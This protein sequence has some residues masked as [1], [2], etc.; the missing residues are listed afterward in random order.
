MDDPDVVNTD[1][2]SRT[3]DRDQ[4]AVVLPDRVGRDHTD[5]TSVLVMII[6]RSGVR[7]GN[8]KYWTVVFS[9][10]VNKYTQSQDAVVGV[11]EECPVLMPLD[12]RSDMGGLQVYFSFESTDIGPKE[13]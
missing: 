13:F 5:E 1:G 10:I 9:D 8:Y 4:R 12:C 6:N 3:G 2:A 11:R 7:T